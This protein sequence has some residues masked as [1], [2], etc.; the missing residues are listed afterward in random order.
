MVTLAVT[1]TPDSHRGAVILAGP[2][3]HRG[4]GCPEVLFVGFRTDFVTSVRDLVASAVAL[5]LG[6]PKN[7][8]GGRTHP[9]HPLPWLRPCQGRR[10]VEIWQDMYKRVAIRHE[11]VWCY[12]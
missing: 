5:A 3:G 1:G 12:P 8:G 10:P 4:P 11:K 7:P 6:S 9:L 2:D